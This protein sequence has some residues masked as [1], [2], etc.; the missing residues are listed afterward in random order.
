MRISWLSA[1]EIASARQ[2]LTA[3][4]ASYGDQQDRVYTACNANHTALTCWDTGDYDRD[5]LSDAVSKL[6][7]EH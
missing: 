7:R 2:A 4:G 5:E 6:Q 1:A 3:G